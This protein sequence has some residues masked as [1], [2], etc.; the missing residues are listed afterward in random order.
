MFDTATTLPLIGAVP[1][2]AWGAVTG[3]IWILIES[4]AY[5]AISKRRDL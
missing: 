2:W 5:I 1:G 4:A 3:V